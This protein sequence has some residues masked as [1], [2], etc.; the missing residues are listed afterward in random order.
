MD[1]YEDYTYIIHD[2]LDGGLTFDGVESM[3]VTVG[4]EDYKDTLRSDLLHR[5]HQLQRRPTLPTPGQKLYIKIELK[6][7]VQ[8]RQEAVKDVVVTY[9]ATVNEKASIGNAPNTNTAYLEYSNNPNQS[10]K[11]GCPSTAKTLAEHV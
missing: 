7:L 1:G 11:D 4:G 6:D 9:T 8:N 5:R 3:T 2:E 10:Q